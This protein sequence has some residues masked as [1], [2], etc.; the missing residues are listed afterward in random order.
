MIAAIAYILP[1]I[2]FIL[3][4]SG[5]VQPWNETKS[6]SENKETTVENVENNERQS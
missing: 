2:V 3:F 6:S 1:A 4:G 5:D